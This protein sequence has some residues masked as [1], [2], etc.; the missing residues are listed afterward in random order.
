MSPC[1][2]AR[3]WTLGILSSQLYIMMLVLVLGWRVV[4]CVMGV[5]LSFN[6]FKDLCFYCLLRVRCADL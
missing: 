2:R 4:L 1:H 6:Q 5:A 3:H